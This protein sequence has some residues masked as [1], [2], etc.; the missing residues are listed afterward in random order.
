MHTSYEFI[1]ESVNFIYLDTAHINDKAV[2]NIA[3]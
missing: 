3:L 2:F 1:N